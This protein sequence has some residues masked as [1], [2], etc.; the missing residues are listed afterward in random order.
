MPRIA[1][2]GGQ[3]ERPLG[4][5]FQLQQERH[6]RDGAIWLPSALLLLSVPGERGWAG[7]GD[8]GVGQGW[9]WGREE[10]RTQTKRG[11]GELRKTSPSQRRGGVDGKMLPT[12]EHVPSP[13]E[14]GYFNPDDHILKI[15]NIVLCPV[16]GRGA[17][18]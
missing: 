11:G 16:K 14:I 15:R 17:E 8:N 13:K 10:M 12:G 2:E 6:Q 7:L 5:G 18:K 9:R 1:E 3:G 4:E